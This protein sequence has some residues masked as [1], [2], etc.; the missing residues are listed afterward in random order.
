MDRPALGGPQGFSQDWRPR[1]PEANVI[2]EI[3]APAAG[4]IAALDGHTI[5]MG[6]VHL[7]GGRMR[8]GD[9]IE[10]SVGYSDMV[11]LGTEVNKG[12]P[13]ARLHAAT[14]KAADVAERAYLDALTI[15]EGSAPQPLLIGRIT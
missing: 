15:G 13:V 8:G 12:D 1:L 14:A 6:V 5:G 11:P 9:R 10:P 4:T 2:R 3:P 7:G